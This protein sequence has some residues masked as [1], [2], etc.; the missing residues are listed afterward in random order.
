M[1]RQIISPNETL[2]FSDYF[3]LNF[4]IEDILAHFGYTFQIQ[5][6]TLPRAIIAET[7]FAALKTR[8]EKGLPHLRLTTEIARREFLIAP[9]LFEVVLY[10][11]TELRVEYP[12]EVNQQ[13]KGTLDYFLQ[14]EHSL[15]VV[16]AKN[17][18]LQRGFTQLA[19]ELVALDHWLGPEAEQLYGAVSIGDVWQFG[20]LDRPSKQV[21]QDFDLYRS[22][23][24]LTDLLSILIGI[25]TG[26]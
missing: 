19:V 17:A 18:D 4:F 14:A 5:K 12:L 16:E 13:L 6:T 9:V 7:Q 26:V 22:P 15:L 10:A 8:L 25:V 11:E 2:T 20:L 21:T 24:D 23:A 1:S 3:R